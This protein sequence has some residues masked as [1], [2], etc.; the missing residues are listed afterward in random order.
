[1]S[2]RRAPHPNAPFEVPHFVPRLGLSRKPKL[3]TKGV[4]SGTLLEQALSIVRP[5]IAK[6][7]S[8]DLGWIEKTALR[9]ALW[10]LEKLLKGS[11]TEDDV[12]DLTQAASGAVGFAKRRFAVGSKTRMALDYADD[13]LDKAHDEL[14]HARS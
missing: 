8:A 12:R 11:A 13:L 4:V 3:S 5:A 6:G 9:L 7:K 2:I 1:M 14:G 10:G